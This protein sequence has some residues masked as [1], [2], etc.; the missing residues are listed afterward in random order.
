MGS[1]FFIKYRLW[2][3]AIGVVFVQHSSVNIY[4]Y[5]DSI[6]VMLTQLSN[7]PQ[8]VQLSFHVGMGQKLPKCLA[9]KLNK[10]TLNIV[11]S[12]TVCKNCGW[13]LE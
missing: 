4:Q 12:L 11:T 7:N 3:L 6:I 1:N 10:D 8:C 9:L 13:P 2:P 5:T